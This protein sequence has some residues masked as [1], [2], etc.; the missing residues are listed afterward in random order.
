MAPLSRG[1]TML[2]QLHSQT[3]SSR[4][5]FSLVHSPEVREAL[6][7]KLP[8]VA[9]EST[10]LTHGLPRPTNLQ[11]GREVEGIVRQQGAVPA[12]IALME[13]RVHVGLQD[14]LLERL[15]NDS[16]AV[17]TS[18]RDFPYVISKKLI[19]GTTVC[20]TLVVCNMAGIEVFA[21]G[22]LGGVHRGAQETM[23]ISADL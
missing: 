18:R 2:R 13:G 6:E 23:D 1:V 11:L 20:G 21:T 14:H 16:G 15:A 10:I 7:Q 3:F 12:T 8:V 5:L 9:L 4:R 22:G 17:K 19:G